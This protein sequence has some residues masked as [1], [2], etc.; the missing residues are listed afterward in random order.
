MIC[1]SDKPPNDGLV[2]FPDVWLASIRGSSNL[3]ELRIF[4]QQR[5]GPVSLAGLKDMVGSLTSLRLLYLSLPQS[6]FPSSESTLDNIFDLARSQQIVEG[7]G[8]SVVIRG[9][10]LAPT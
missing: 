6:Q 5:N 10:E 3:A 4:Y 1:G 7:R 2:I 9:M 8:G